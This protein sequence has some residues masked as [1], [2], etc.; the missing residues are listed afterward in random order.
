MMVDY[1]FDGLDI[2]WEYPGGGGLEGNAAR[3]EDTENF[4]LLLSEL[5]TQLDAQGEQDGRA[6]LLTIA[7][8]AG[9]SIARLT[10]P[11]SIPCW[12]G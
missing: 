7:A 6:Y 1:G 11:R 4:T 10:W 9:G 5:R 12:T 2:D 8:P 3:P